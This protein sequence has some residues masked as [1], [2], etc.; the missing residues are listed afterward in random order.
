MTDESGWDYSQIPERKWTWFF[1][2][3]HWMELVVS[4]SGM[5]YYGTDWTCQSG[6]GY[7]GGFQTFEDFF[8]KGSI[9]KMP[10]KIAK[11]VREYL[12]EHRS[13]GGATLRLVYAHEIEGFQ[14]SGVF[15]HLDGSPIHIKEVKAQEEMLLYDGSIT[16]GDHCFSF[17][18]ILRSADAMKKVNGE[19]QIQIQVGENHAVLKT[20]EDDKGNLRTKLVEG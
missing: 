6:G 15:V 1:E 8:V 13:K 12:K 2:E 5:N 17:V 3:N 10:R 20:I 11:E 19:I 16:L 18:F 4:P 14:L 9:Q 7:F